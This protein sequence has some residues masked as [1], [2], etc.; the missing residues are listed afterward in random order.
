MREYYQN[1]AMNWARDPSNN[2]SITDSSNN[3][4][5]YNANDLSGAVFSVGNAT[6]KSNAVGGATKQN[7]NSID[8]S[9]GS[10]IFSSSYYIYFLSFLVIYCIA[11]FVLGYAFNVPGQTLGPS[12]SLS[13]ML[14]ILFMGGLLLFLITY[15]FSSSPDQ[16][17]NFFKHLWNNTTSFINTPSS[18]FSIIMFIIIFYLIVY[19]LRIPMNSDG[20]PMFISLIENGAWILFVIIGIN[21]FFKYILRIDLANLMATFQFWQNPPVDVSVRVVDVSKNNVT[22][23]VSKNEVFNISNNLY[24]YDDAQAICTAYGAKVA[25]YDQ[26]EAT[27][28]NGGEWCNY[29]WSDG[30]MILFPTQKATWKKL[31][32]K[33][34]HK[35]D[36]G[37]PGINGGYIANPYMKF[38][39]N[40]YGTKPKA[41][42]DDL[43]RMSSKQNQVYPLSEKDKALQ[44]KVDY[45]KE[46]AADLLKINSYNTKKWSELSGN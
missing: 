25:T 13:Q 7:T 28:N 22:V 5:K 15:Y 11:Y 26:V 23:D 12:S 34:Q 10:S 32:D 4:Y 6:T 19:L 29:G 39:V 43:N 37:R 9:A 36:C 40:C 21:D 24:T 41:T 8:S 1:K 18:I 42:S 17:L 2:G 31:Q 14:D 16:Q 3:N 45:W 35:N 44:A 30:Q 46:N 20:K 27:Y 38:G 33:P